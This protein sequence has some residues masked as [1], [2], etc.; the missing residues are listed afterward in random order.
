ML[1]LAATF[2][3]HFP[4]SSLSSS[5]PTS[6][7]ITA[8]SQPIPTSTTIP[9]R[10]TEKSAINMFTMNAPNTSASLGG[11]YDVVLAAGMVVL[12]VVVIGLGCLLVVVVMVLLV[13]R[14][15]KKK[16]EVAENSSGLFNPYYMPV[17][18]NLSF[19]HPLFI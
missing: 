14:R 19:N 15:K 18:S 1:H 17:Y 6:V 12:V 4:K 11:V 7:I 5:I 13:C 2:S 9:Q 10:I 3:C 8:T 16:L